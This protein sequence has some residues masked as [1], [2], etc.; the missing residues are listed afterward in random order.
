MAR[1]ARRRDQRGAAL[2]LLL[3]LLGLAG[4]GLLM[5]AYGQRSNQLQRRQQTLTQLAEARE[6]LLGF[7]AQYGRLPRPALSALDGQEAA[8]ACSDGAAC[9]GYLPWVTLGLPAGDA[10]GKLLRYSVAPAMTTSPVTAVLAVA[11]RRLLGR[12]RRGAVVPQSGQEHCSVDTP[13][14]AALLL[15]SGRNLGTSVYGI[16]QGN[17]GLAN[18]DE[19]YNNNQGADFLSRAATD[20]PRAAGGEFD[21]LVLAVDVRRLYQRMNAAGMLK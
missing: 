17:D 18:S 3:L 12:D 7:A 19:Q 8:Q 16:A 10:W 13:C 4:A 6:A 20:D 5:A 11:D 2:I 15:S 21:D 1:P 9:S 14:A